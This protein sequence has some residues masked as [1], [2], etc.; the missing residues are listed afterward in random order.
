MRKFLL[1][2]LLLMPSVAHAGTYQVGGTVRVWNRETGQFEYISVAERIEASSRDAAL[3]YARDE[4]KR[5]ANEIGST[6]DPNP[7][8]TANPDRLR[9]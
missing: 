1:A 8:V 5:R 9:R 2:S 7:K 6:T 3:R 4:L